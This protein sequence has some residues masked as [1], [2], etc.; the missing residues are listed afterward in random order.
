[1]QYYKFYLIHL[2][3]TITVAVFRLLRQQMA[4]VLVLHPFHSSVETCLTHIGTF[5]LNLPLEEAGGQKMVD[6]DDLA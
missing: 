2:D 5:W 4:T 6:Q 3:T 1:M